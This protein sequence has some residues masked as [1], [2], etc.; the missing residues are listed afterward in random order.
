MSLKTNQ[1]I[2]DE[3]SHWPQN[4]TSGNFR[5]ILTDPA[6]YMAPCVAGVASR[7]WPRT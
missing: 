6:W 7:A 5:T 1:E 3:F 2:L 4:L